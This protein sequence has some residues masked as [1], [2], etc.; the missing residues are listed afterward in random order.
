[1]RNRIFLIL[2][3]AALSASLVLPSAALAG[4]QIQDNGKGTVTL[5]PVDNQAPE[6]ASGT[7]N[8][9]VQ[10]TPDGL[11][12][13]SVSLEI[14]HLPRKAGKAFVF[15]LVDS[16]SGAQIPLGAFQTNKSGTLDKTT[17]TQTAI[18]SFKPY[19]KVIVTSEKLNK[20]ETL[21]SGPVV[22]QGDLN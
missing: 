2:T 18:L 11:Y 12:N 8:F 15:W 19:D 4:S 1:M 5:N 7:A 20:E 9:K 22:L 3:V 6:Q 10:E 16:D 14:S 17:K 13:F 21:K